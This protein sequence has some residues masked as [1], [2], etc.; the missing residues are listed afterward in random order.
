LTTSW[1]W[2]I[3]LRTTADPM[4]PAPPVIRIFMP[5]FV[6]GRPQGRARSNG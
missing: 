4:K 3:A 1:P 2:A 6:C 5:N